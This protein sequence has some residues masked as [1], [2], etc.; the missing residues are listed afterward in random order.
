MEYTEKS[1]RPQA[2]ISAIVL[3]GLL[4]LLFVFFMMKVPDP[5][6]RSL[7]G[8]GIELN[9]GTTDAGSGDLQTLNQANASDKN[10]ESAAADV[11]AASANTEESNQEN[12]PQVEDQTTVITGTEDVNY[13]VKQKEVKKSTEVSVNKTDKA[14]NTKTATIDKAKTN[15]TNG[16]AKTIGG[17]NNG[18]QQGKTG[19]QGS[20][21]GTVDSKALYGEEGN[22]GPGKGGVGGN[23]DI[24]GWNWDDRPNIKDNSDESGRI[25]IGFKI[26]DQGEVIKVWKIENNLSP[27]VYKL[28]EDE[29]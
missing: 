11:T 14:P 23:L 26:D 24:A 17:N 29:V 5:P 1:S 3:H 13:E 8:S 22:G 4:L 7:G 12:K 18:D 27:S 19:D 10:V 6:L 25:V 15:G 16:T 21:T 28:Y 9:Y 20:K 2:I